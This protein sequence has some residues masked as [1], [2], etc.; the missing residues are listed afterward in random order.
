VASRF[1]VEW[2]ESASTDLANIIK[3]IAND[4][5]INAS[6]VLKKIRQRANTLRRFPDRGHMVPELAEL[7]VISYR[8]LAVP[9]YRILYRIDKSR[10]LVLAVLDGRRDLKQILS[11]RLLR[12]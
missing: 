11:E 2:T 6:K 9:P 12:P 8:E 10:V 3:F 7:E 1:R 4:S 5:P